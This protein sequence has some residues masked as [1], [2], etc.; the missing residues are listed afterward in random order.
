MTKRSP[1]N[2]S[3]KEQELIRHR[4]LKLIESRPLGVDEI[5]EN[6][7]LNHRSVE[8]AVKWLREKGMIK[9]H[10]NLMDMR[11]CIYERIRKG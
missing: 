3:H 4:I 1:K 5:I 11:K 6:T 8:L 7:R 10:P 2:K 9:S